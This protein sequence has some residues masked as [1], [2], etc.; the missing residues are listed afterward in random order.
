ME[1]NHWPLVTLG[2]L[3][4]ITH[5]YAFEGAYFRDGPPGDILLTP[6]NFAIGGGYQ[7]EKLKYYAGPVPEDY[8]LRTGDLLVTMTD[9]SKNGDTLGYPAFVPRAKNSERYLHNQ[10]LGKM[11]IRPGAPVIKEFLYFL[12]CTRAYRNEVLASATGTTVKHTSPGRIRGFRLLLP[13]LS[14]QRAIANILGSLDDK[15]ELNRRMNETLEAIAQALFTSW[16]VNFDPVRAKA[17]GRQPLGMDAETAALFPDGFEESALGRVPSGWQVATIGE[18][19]QVVGGSTPSTQESTY[20]N[21]GTIH[22]ATPKDLATL[23]SPV[24]LDTERCL[25]ELGLQQI[26]SGLLPKGTVLLSSRAPIGYLAIAKIPV[27]I[28]Q[29]FIAMICNQQLPNHYILQWA[30]ANMGAIES[31]ANGTTFLEIS[32][33]NFR[34]LPI[35]L[36]PKI[37]LGQFAHQAEVLHQKVVGN[38]EQSHTLAAM[39]NEVLPKL[40]SGEIRIA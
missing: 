1:D 38:L 33:A 21:G 2:D 14:E 23:T 15:I 3:V 16:F 29:G 28:N 11:L 40:L 6:G 18:V 39:R 34:P 4:D 32:K 22:W 27:A 12:L 7:D 10:R 5:G 36:P 31:R 25:T 30:R 17:A 19:V 8:V 35:L 13:P 20:W 37:L 24:L 26:G 9:L